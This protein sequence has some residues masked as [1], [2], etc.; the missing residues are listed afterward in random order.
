MDYKQ[1]LENLRQQVFS[2]APVNEEVK[3]SSFIS[4]RVQ[5]EPMASTEDILS[6]SKDWLREIKMS[7][8][9]AKSKAPAPSGGFGEGF[10]DALNNSKSKMEVDREEGKAAF[11]KRRG[12]TPSTYSPDKPV[13]GG[14]R[15]VLGEASESSS[16]GYGNISQ[17]QIEGIIRQ[18]A[19]AR[20]MDPDVAVAI[21]RAEGAG[22]Y[23]SQIKRTGKGVH[24]GKE[25]SWGPY[26]LFT[27]GGLGNTYEQKTGRDLT[28][29]NTEEGI[30]N[31]I[32]FALDAAV[33][34]GWTP[35]YGRKHAKVGVRDGLQGAKK[36][37]NWK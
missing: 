28:K 11:I 30:T 1:A 31:Q 3:K 19:S 8:E 10:A 26:Q 34:E 12:D 24:G 33:D 27:G 2:D 6:I 18:E 5:T 23:Q 29:D 25:A 22:N 37:G 21:F 20:N 16:P 14:E 4:P 36:L 35:W 17:K 32:R 7:S 9:A 13:E 15:P